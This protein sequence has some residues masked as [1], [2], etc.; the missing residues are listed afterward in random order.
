MSRCIAYTHVFNSDEDRLIFHIVLNNAS[1]ASDGSYHDVDAARG[2]LTERGEFCIALHI[3]LLDARREVLVRRGAR[4]VFDRF[5]FVRTFSRE[6]VRVL[7]ELDNF[8]DKVVGD[9]LWLLS[10]T[11]KVP[12][13]RWLQSMYVTL[14]NAP[15]LQHSRVRDMERH[16]TRHIVQ[17]EMERGG[18]LSELHNALSDAVSRALAAESALRAA[19]TSLASAMRRRCGLGALSARGWLYPSAAQIDTGWSLTPDEIGAQHV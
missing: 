14:Y 7:R 19:D 3:P 15:A 2:D 1:T 8:N 16:T 9:H 5:V 13:M 10:V 6:R 17:H 12:L 11:I 18:V 4:C